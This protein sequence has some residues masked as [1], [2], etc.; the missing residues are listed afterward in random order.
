MMLLL[1]QQMSSHESGD[2]SVFVGWSYKAYMDSRFRGN[3]DVRGTPAY[4]TNTIR[5]PMAWLGMTSRWLM[6]Q[7]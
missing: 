2:P 1:E 6:R 7:A 4:S 3:D 5:R